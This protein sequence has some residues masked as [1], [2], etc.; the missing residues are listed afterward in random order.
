VA[1]AQ[2]SIYSMQLE[3]V[4]ITIDAP[5]A[6]K[7]KSKTILILYAL[8]NGNTTEQTMGRKLQ[9]TTG[10]SIFNT[11]AHKQNLYGRRL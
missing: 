7:Y 4:R 6:G 8:P 3:D 2:D 1:G 10:I 11:S 5:A 9:A